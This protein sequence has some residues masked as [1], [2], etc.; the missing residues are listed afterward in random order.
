MH[1]ANVSLMFVHLNIQIT[2]YEL[3]VSNRFQWFKPTETPCHMGT[4]YYLQSA[5]YVL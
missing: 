1:E 5:I 2:A 4:I 3:R